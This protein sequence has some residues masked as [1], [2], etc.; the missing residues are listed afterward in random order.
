MAGCC[1][2]RVSVDAL[3]LKCRCSAT[4]ASDR[5]LAEGMD[6]EVSPYACFDWP[7]SGVGR[8]KSFVAIADPDTISVGEFWILTRLAGADPVAQKSCDWR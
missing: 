8:E 7:F 5:I 4:P 2:D 6:G 3:P 1:I